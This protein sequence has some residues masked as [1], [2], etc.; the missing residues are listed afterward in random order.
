MLPAGIEVRLP[1][2]TDLL[3][4]HG[5]PVSDVDTIYP[6]ITAQGLSRKLGLARPGILACGHTHVPFVRTIAGIAVVNCGSTGLPLDGDPR[7]TYAMIETRRGGKPSARI[8][9]FSY[10]VET[11]VQ[12][13]RTGGLPERLCRDFAEGSRTR[14]IQ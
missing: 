2:G 8:V 7:P 4:V 9:R 11:V 6:S 3:I 10:P 5:S 12:A 13:V 1:G 14:E